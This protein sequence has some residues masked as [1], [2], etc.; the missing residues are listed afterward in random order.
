[1]K[2]TIKQLIKKITSYHPASESGLKRNWSYYTGGM[3]DTGGWD[4][5]KLLD[6]KKAELEDCLN[7]LIKE[8]E[9]K[10]KPIWTD[11]ETRQMNN[12]IQFEDGTWMTEKFVNDFKKFGEEM[13]KQ[14][15]DI[16]MGKK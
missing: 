9:P 13:D 6:A 14:V 5:A 15:L 12:I 4:Y 1:M 10:P 2:L 3:A 11:E 16:L 8:W 7:D